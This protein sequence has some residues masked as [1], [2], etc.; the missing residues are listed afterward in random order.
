VGP[1]ATEV[2][3]SALVILLSS[4]MRILGHREVGR[5][6][7]S[8]CP[9]DVKEIFRAALMGGACAFIL[10]HNHPSGSVE[11]SPEDLAVTGQVQ[12]AADLLGI[13][14]L[15]HIIVGAGSD[16]ELIHY[17]MREHGKL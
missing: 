3:E 6:S 1:W 16:G 9:V 4:R 12:V 17:S 15:D 13:P 14:M 10:C 2:Q 5:G 11:P 7:T 8:S